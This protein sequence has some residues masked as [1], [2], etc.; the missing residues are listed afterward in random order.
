MKCPQCRL[1]EMLVKERKDNIVTFKCP[2][3]NKEATEELQ[4]VNNEPE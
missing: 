2:K 3:C 4:E 1:V